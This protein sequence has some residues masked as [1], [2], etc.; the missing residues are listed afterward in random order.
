MMQL[1][2]ND[3]EGLL[4]SSKME[5]LVEKDLGARLFGELSRAVD[6]LEPVLQGTFECNQWSPSALQ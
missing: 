6:R 3:H 1:V 4:F 5:R 2:P